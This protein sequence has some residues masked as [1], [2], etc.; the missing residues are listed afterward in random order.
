MKKIS[1]FLTFLLMLGTI[2][3]CQ[4]ASE[5]NNP[6]DPNTQEQEKPEEQPEEKPEEQPEDKVDY[7]KLTIDNIKV[8]SAGYDGISLK[9]HFT[10]PEAC[11]NEE[12]EY[13]ISNEEICYIDEDKVYFLK[14]GTTRVK[15][16]SEHLTAS[17]TVSCEDYRFTSQSTTQINRL[18]NN[19]T[20]G[21]TLFLGDSF[22][23]FWRN[24]TGITE[25]FDTAFA[26]Y[27]VYNI[28]I[29]ATTSHHWRAINNKIAELEIKPKN[30]VI[31]I[32]INNVDDDKE[33]G[34]QCAAGVIALI[35]DYLEMFPDANIYYLSITRCAGY[36][37]FN[38]ESHEKSNSLLKEFCDNTDRVHYLDIMGLYG[39]DYASYQQDGLHPNQAGYDLFKNLIKT[40]VPIDTIN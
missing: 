31:N 27:A 18:K 30:I 33:T 32:G 1:M 11:V 25:N 12:F 20:E 40:E 21:D 16:V 34:K 14:A 2:V 10:N 23:E 24:K 13:E 26:G 3:G 5:P 38:W 19:F 15:A 28:G 17:F 37:A 35:E 6:E 29:S 7:G 8:F 39:E 36:F 9:Y 22:F 4:D